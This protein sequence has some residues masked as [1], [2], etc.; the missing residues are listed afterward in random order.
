MFETFDK[1]N[2]LVQHIQ[3]TLAYFWMVTYKYHLFIHFSLEREK[4]KKKTF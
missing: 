1:W 2:L 3:M 4:M